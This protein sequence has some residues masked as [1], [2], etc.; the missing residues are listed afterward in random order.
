MTDTA[1]HKPNPIPNLLTGLRLV[2]GVIMFLLLGGSITT[3]YY[4]SGEDQFQ[5]YKA[6]FALFVI[7]GAT[8]WLDGYLARRWHAESR[9]GAILDPIA[10]K[11]LVAGA[12]VGLLATGTGAAVVIPFGLILFR[13]FAVSALRETTAGVVELKVTTLAKWK[14]TLQIVA[15]GV[16]MFMLAWGPTF[17]EAPWR[18][19]YDLIANIL[20]WLAALVTLWTGWQYFS[21]AREGLRG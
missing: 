20:V 2:T 8:D 19:Q 1:P 18:P 12:I 11:I 16:N 17:A 6:A 3:G 10:D 5:I 13:E 21:K 15:I 7:A 14:T 9:W 4:L